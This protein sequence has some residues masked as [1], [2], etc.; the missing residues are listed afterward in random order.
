VSA[1]ASQFQPAHCMALQPGGCSF[2]S[3]DDQPFCDCITAAIP[4]F[5]FFF[6]KGEAPAITRILVARFPARMQ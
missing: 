6:F 2:T 1:L 4:K 3:S 5:F